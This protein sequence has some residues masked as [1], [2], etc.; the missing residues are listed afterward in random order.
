MVRYLVGLLS[1]VLAASFVIVAQ[2]EPTLTSA[3]LPSYPPLACQARIHGLVKVRFTLPARSKEPT[4]IAVLSG[5]PMLK[6]AALENVKTWRFDNPYAVDR[7]YETT[8]DYR[9]SERLL[10]AGQKKR[11]TVT[12]ESFDRVEVMTD[13]Y[14]SAVNY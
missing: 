1:F 3:A 2:T 8:F 9:V 4:N 14:E 7:S 6:E 13:A 11:L 5:H 12:L 10:T